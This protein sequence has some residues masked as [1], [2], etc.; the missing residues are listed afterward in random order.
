MPNKKEESEKKENG[1]HSNSIY[2]F[3]ELLRSISKVLWTAA[4]LILFIGLGKL[5]IFR[6]S[7]SSSPK[8]TVQKT[9][10]EKIDWGNVND[11]IRMSL[12]KSRKYAESIASKELTQWV[13]RLMSRVDDDFLPWYFDYW[14]QQKMGLEG[15]IAQIW[16]WVDSDS[17]TAA[18]KIT[19]DVQSE[20]SSKVLRPQIAQL[21]LERIVNKTVGEYSKSLSDNLNKIPGK[22]NIKRADWERYIGDISVMTGNVDAGRSV[23]ISLKV[24]TGVGAGGLYL[25]FRSI[26]PVI[27]KIGAKIS[28][29]MSA[30]F[31]ARMATKTGGKVAYK[32]GGKFLGSIIAI[33]II[34]WDVWDHFNTKKKAMPVLRRNIRDYLIELKRSVL[35]DPDYGVMTVI[36][37]MELGIVSELKDR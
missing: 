14:T 11:D 31:A 20:F 3:S 23:S 18:E 6:S 8:K 5:F 21:E 12:E 1:S 33:G 30:K 22:Y 7:K 13:D 36:H 15:L 4:I 28:T 17:P 35:T 37:R 25:M 34:I 16:H 2:A 32:A 24:L 29:K 26:K 9:V 19:E 27:S 10:L